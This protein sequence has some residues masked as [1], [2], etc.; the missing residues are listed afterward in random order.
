MCAH[1]MIYP[2][3]LSSRF[4]IIS[5]VN[6]NTSKCLCGLSL[7][8]VSGCFSFEATKIGAGATAGLR[9]RATNGEPA[10]HVVV[11]NNGWYLFNCWPLA[12]G[13]ASV[14]AE[15]PWKLFQDDVDERTLHDR[16]TRH[17]A[18]KKCDIEEMNVFGDEQVLLSIPGTSF[19]LPIPY[20]LTFRE[21]QIS[22]VLV[23]R[24]GGAQ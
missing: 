2:V 1:F 8:A 17:A 9:L 15:F 20:I 22:G 6:F 16:I 10:E 12:T 19:P 4:G 24:T 11:A 18:F 23:R 5:T 13:N 7:L 21:K 14:G 3:L